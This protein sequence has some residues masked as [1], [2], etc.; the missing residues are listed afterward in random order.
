MFTYLLTIANINFQ[1]IHGYNK[2]SGNFT[3]YDKSST[4]LKKNLKILR[5]D[6]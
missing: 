5:S 4:S 2:V 1:K 3:K 6:Y